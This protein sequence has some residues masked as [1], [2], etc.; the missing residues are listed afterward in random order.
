MEILDVLR[1]VHD[2]REKCLHEIDGKEHIWLFQLVLTPEIDIN[3]VFAEHT[4]NLFFLL[5]YFNH[6]NTV[7]GSIGMLSKTLEIQVH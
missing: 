4:G 6:W 5:E 2:Q 7:Q 3:I 1:S